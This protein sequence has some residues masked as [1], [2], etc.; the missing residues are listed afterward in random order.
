MHY[1]VGELR[2][3]MLQ[4]KLFQFPKRYRGISVVKSGTYHLEI[5]S[6][7]LGTRLAIVFVVPDGR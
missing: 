1:R 3:Y 4:M 7:D 2:L 5:W 6:H